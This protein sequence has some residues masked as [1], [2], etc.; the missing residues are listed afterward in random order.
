LTTYTKT[1]PEL[2][3][4]ADGNNII[5]YQTTFDEDSGEDIGDYQWMEG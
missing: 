4:D 3:K 5:P 1:P 2:D